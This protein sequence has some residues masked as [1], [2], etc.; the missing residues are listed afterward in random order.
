MSEQL[1]LR[2]RKKRE[3]R[4][5]ISDIAMGLFMTRGFD[6][7]TV[8]EVAR[9]ADVSVNTV[10]NY[11]KTK[12]DLFLDRQEWYEDEPSRI[13]RE[14]RPG[15]SV[16]AALRRD[17]LD[18]IE[19]R[20]WRSGL[21]EGMEVF[22]R[23]INESPALTARMRELAERREARFAE[24]LADETDAD[25]DDIRPALV[26]AQISAVTRTLAAIGMRRKMAGET[27]E[28]IASDVRAQ[29]EL[30]FDLLEKGIGDY[31]VR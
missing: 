21:Q 13:V 28:Q 25:D 31:G 5:R 15:E 23:T 8:A 3:T 9:V 18:A 10:F 2:E 7:V 12:E 22:I 14:R 4:Q 19:Q 20:H 26:A 17:F 30:A 16:I 6:N 1:G 27:F 24:T 11:F 29:A